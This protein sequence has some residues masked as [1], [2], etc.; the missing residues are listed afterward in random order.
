MKVKMR[1]TRI[2]G[3]TRSPTKRCWLPIIRLLL[4]L[5]LLLQLWELIVGIQPPEVA[6]IDHN[7][8][9]Q[10]EKGWSER[11]GKRIAKTSITYVVFGILLAASLT[12]G[13]CCSALVVHVMNPS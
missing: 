1:L 12:D 4:V 3:S 10:L 11:L 5:L 13:K 7:P 6:T 9:V 8:G 2:V